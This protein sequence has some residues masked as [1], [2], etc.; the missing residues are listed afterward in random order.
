MPLTP[1]SPADEGF[2]AVCIDD[3]IREGLGDDSTTD[4]LE[5]LCKDLDIDTSHAY[6]FFRQYHQGNR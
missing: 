1:L 5:N 3:C 6:P 2:L 4:R